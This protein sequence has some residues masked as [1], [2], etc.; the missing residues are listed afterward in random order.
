M[1]SRFAKMLIAAAGLAVGIVLVL[2]VTADAAK[3][4]KHRKSVATQQSTVLANARTRGEN[5]FMRGPLVSSREYLGDDPDPFIRLQLYRDLG[6][7]YGG[8]E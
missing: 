8:A 1:T 5:L 7:R 2:P 4:R 3:A 6:A